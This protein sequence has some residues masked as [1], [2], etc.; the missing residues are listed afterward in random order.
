[1]RRL[2]P[3]IVSFHR[4][5]PRHT[6]LYTPLLPKHIPE[7]GQTGSRW[8]PCNK[9][10]ESWCTYHH[11]AS[12]PPPASHAIW[13][14]TRSLARA[15]WLHWEMRSTNRKA[16]GRCTMDLLVKIGN[17]QRSPATKGLVAWDWLIYTV[18]SDRWSHPPTSHH[19]L[20]VRGSCLAF[21]RSPSTRTLC[22]WCESTVCCTRMPD[23]PQV[24]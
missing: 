8:I 9:S 10:L 7:Q 20:L 19:I 4:P 6:P 17:P 14:H 12:Q 11:R 23:H 21:R 22:C 15:T 24:E 16:T 5:P 1:V 13:Q 18:C 2:P 3:V